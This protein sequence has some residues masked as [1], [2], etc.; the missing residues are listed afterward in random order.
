MDYAAPP[1]LLMD[2]PAGIAGTRRT[3]QIMKNCILQGKQNG[4]INHQGLIIAGS[5][6]SRNYPAVAAAMQQWVKSHIKYVPDIRGIETVRTADYTLKYGAG[7]CDDQSVLLAS[8]LETVGQPTRLRAVAFQ[9]GRFSHVYVQVRPGDTGAWQ[10]V[11][12][13]INKPYGWNPPG[14]VQDLVIDI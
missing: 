13:I 6:P 3:L 4:L 2:L 14:V 7:D 5:V 12:T 9:P 11:E 10:G 8:L 1:S